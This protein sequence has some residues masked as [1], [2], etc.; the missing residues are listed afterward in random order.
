MTLRAWITAIVGRLR[1]RLCCHKLLRRE[2]KWAREDVDRLYESLDRMHARA[3]RAEA[4]T[5]LVQQALHFW[6]PA[7]QDGMPAEM[8]DRIADDA[9]M[10]MG[11]EL[12]DEPDAYQRGWITLP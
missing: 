7:Q 3:E 12:T 5:R 6:L 10:L 2:L 1:D 8:L 11:A 4:D 9:M